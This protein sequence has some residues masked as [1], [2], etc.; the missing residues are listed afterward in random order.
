MVV[1][2]D[3]CY[4]FSYGLDE[5]RLGGWVRLVQRTRVQCGTVCS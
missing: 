1:Y 5:F 3:K 2:W 4:R